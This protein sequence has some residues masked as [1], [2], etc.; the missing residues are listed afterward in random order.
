MKA[1]FIALDTAILTLC[2]CAVGLGLLL[3]SPLFVLLLLLYVPLNIIPSPHR[4]RIRSFR[5]RVCGEGSDLLVRET[6]LSATF[7]KPRKKNEEKE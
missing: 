2:A 5:L 3:R 6:H 7:L 4:F 1:L